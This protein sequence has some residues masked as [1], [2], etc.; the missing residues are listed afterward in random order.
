MLTL[1]VYRLINIAKTVAT[2][3]VWV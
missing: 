2:F 1:K 3:S